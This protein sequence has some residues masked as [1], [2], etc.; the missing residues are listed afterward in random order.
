MKPFEDKEE[1]EK[2]EAERE[3]LIKVLTRYNIPKDEQRFLVRRISIITEK[4][5][6]KARYAKDAKDIK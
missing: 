2:I 1:I 5:L 4:L 3:D 6:E